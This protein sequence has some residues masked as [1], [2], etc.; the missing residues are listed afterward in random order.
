MDHSHDRDYTPEEEFDIARGV[1]EADRDLKHAAHHV[2]NALAGNPIDADRLDFLDKLI[3]ESDDPL[4]LAPLDSEKGVHY[5]TAALHAY[6]LAHVGR[7]ADAVNLILQVAQVVPQI[8]YLAWAIR[9]LINEPD[10]RLDVDLDRLVQS[11]FAINQRHSG[12]TIT[13][14]EGES[15]ITRGLRLMQLVAPES[16]DDFRL[17]FA[18]SVMTRK[19][20]RFD[21]AIRIAE[22]AHQRMPEYLLAT[23][24]GMAYAAKGDFDGWLRWYRVCL[25][26]DPDNVPTRLD[27]GDRHLDRK[28][29]AEAVRWYQEA[30]DRE[31]D[32]EWA[33]PSVA[34]AR[35]KNGEGVQWLA[36]LRRYADEHPDNDRA[37]ELA[38][39]DE[40]YIGYLP[41]PT[42][43]TVNLLGQFWDEH[44]K[45]Q[46]VSGMLS[47]HTTAIEAPSVRL[48]V[49]MQ[50]AAWSPPKVG[51][52]PDLPSFA[53]SLPIE[54]TP[55][56]RYPRTPV[57]FQVWE[58][59]DPPPEAGDDKSLV[60][61]SVP[62]MKPPAN[63]VHGLVRQLVNRRYRRHEWY[64]AA[65]Q[66]LSSFGKLEPEAIVA[67]M[68]HLPKLPGPKTFAPQ[69]I[70]LCQVAA[71]M[72]GA[73]LD[74][75]VPWAK[76]VRRELLID[77]AN[78]PLDWSV[79]A[80][81]VALGEVAVR[82]PDAATDVAE[83]F[84]TLLAEQP[85]PGHVTYLSALLASI[86]NWPDAPKPLRD[87]A[88]RTA[89]DDLALDE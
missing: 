60:V 32:S 47:V 30:V 1:Y 21:E 23:A 89:G 83:V 29:Y 57:R 67:V 65:G 69:W 66:L 7:T 50:L 51:E 39:Q 22:Q 35:W 13:Y 2:G 72:L 48:S 58:Y 6:I 49:E 73:H 80:A 14:R 36:K 24:A 70:Y 53:T 59:R 62:T 87:E 25:E 43:A 44:N 41:T 26:H 86:Q 4:E 15:E 84:H 46:P 8:P 81:V 68:A 88:E 34:Y 56:P 10:A 54:A 33:V 17:E 61:L 79:D 76:S 9:W 20:G 37:N 18:R 75:K 63:E 52:K 28:M 38:W 11:V 16:T 12:D 40:P 31:P 19:L 27:L 78:G 42:D 74:R 82:E 77:L 45:G 5:V 3:D 85:R 55:D 64:D 71:A